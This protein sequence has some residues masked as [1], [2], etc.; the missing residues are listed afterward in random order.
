MAINNKN[1]KIILSFAIIFLLFVFLL[2]GAALAQSTGNADFPNPLKWDTIE[3]V[4]GSVLTFLQGVIATVAVLFIVIGGVL[5][6]TS[7]GDE[8]RITTAKNCWTGAAIG[9]AITLA[10]P[11]LLKDIRTVLGATGSSSVD[12]AI[13]LKQIATNTLT[14]LLSIVGIIAIISLVIGGIMYMTAYGD[15]KRVETGKKIVTY[16]II[17]IAI[18]LGSL[19][20]VKQIAGLL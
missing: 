2:P 15:E 13:G 14:L 10:A 16:S 7:A 1:K 8:K 17:G 5:Y 11:S 18:A 6:M 12:A 9:M 19:V 3:G 20:I 4:L